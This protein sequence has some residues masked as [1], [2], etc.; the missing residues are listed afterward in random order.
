MFLSGKT[1]LTQH[2]H[3]ESQ[4]SL[5]PVLCLQEWPADLGP[6]GQD[7]T[8]QGLQAFVGQTSWLQ[9]FSL[10]LPREAGLCVAQHVLQRWH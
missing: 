7:W 8:L 1:G 10:Q 3:F 5:I 2:G 9:A 4:D 6:I